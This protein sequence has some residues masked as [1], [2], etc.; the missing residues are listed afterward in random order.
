MT[1]DILCLTNDQC[2]PLSVSVAVVLDFL[3]RLKISVYLG[4]I[5]IIKP[6]A[7]KADSVYVFFNADAGVVFAF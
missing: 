7:L 5:V 1:V 3:Y 4:K 6:S 2:S